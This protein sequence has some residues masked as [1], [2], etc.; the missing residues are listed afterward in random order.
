MS[1]QNVSNLTLVDPTNDAE[2]VT[3]ETPDINEM[4]SFSDGEGRT[5]MGE[6]P[7]EGGDPKFTGVF[8]VGSNLGPMRMQMEFP[9]GNTVQDCF[10]QF[11]AMAQETINKAQ[12]EAN[13]KNRIVT[14]DQ[15]RKSKISLP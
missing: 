14:P 10:A 5:V 12:E 8:T 13:D 6:Y 2:D 3:P 1:E 9:E 7:I 4:R 15:M 11:D